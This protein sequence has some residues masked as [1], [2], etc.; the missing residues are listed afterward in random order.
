M[1][2]G[3]DS[4]VEADDA[5][6]VVLDVTATD[7][8]VVAVVDELED[9][10]DALAATAKEPPQTPVFELPVPIRDFM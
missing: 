3:Q 2:P 4:V 10:D 7:V 1:D 5:D 8:D 6:V 9:I